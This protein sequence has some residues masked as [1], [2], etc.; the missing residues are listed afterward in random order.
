[1]DSARGAECFKF[2]RSLMERLADSGLPMTPLNVQRRMRPEIS[3]FIRFNQCSNPFEICC[4]NI[5][6]SFRHILYPRL[7]DNDLVKNY[8]PV[9]GMQKNVYFLNHTNREGGLD[10]SVS[11]FNTYEVGIVLCISPFSFIKNH[12]PRSK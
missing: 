6:L 5:F 4:S 1:M 2:D 11:K 3:Q 9:K 7:E 12:Y 10:D 8:P